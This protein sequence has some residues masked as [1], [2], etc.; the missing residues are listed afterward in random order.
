MSEGKNPGALG[1]ARAKNALNLN[2]LADLQDRYGSLDK[3][4]LT[5]FSVVRFV[6][7]LIIRKE[8]PAVTER[9][10]GERFDMQTM[11]S[12]MTKVLARSGLINEDQAEGKAVA[13]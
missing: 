13:E 10:V 12:E 2:D 11:Q 6:L 7:W 5:N 4:D 9:E 8:E 1:V 3:I